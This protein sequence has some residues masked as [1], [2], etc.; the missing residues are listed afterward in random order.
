VVIFASLAVSVLL[1]AG[2]SPIR[3][4]SPQLAPDLQ[5]ANAELSLVPAHRG[6]QGR[7]D[8]DRRQ[9]GRRVRR[10]GRSN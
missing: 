5:P 3:S 1:V 8:R 4:V 9:R 10:S 7:G 2:A 6:R